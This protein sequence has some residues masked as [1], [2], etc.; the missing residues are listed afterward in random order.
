MVSKSKGNAKKWSPSVAR[1]GGKAGAMKETGVPD[2]GTKLTTLVPVPPLGTVK[3]STTLDNTNNKAIG[4]DSNTKGK[5][6]EIA[7][8]QGAMSHTQMRVGMGSRR[9]TNSGRVIDTKY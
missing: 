5:G 3:V 6:Q 9:A 1:E 2:V 7:L 4:S 8:L